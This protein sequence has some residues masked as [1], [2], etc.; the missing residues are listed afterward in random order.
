MIDPVEL[1]GDI[2][3]DISD[4]VDAVAKARRISRMQCVAEILKQ[5]ADEKVHEATL[6]NR[7]RRGKGSEAES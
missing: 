3:R 5:W 2:E 6:V 7:L 4:I 1:R